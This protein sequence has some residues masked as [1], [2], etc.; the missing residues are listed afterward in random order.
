MSLDCFHLKLLLLIPAQLSAQQPALVLP[1]PMS[2]SSTVVMSS[3]LDDFALVFAELGLWPV[4]VE[5]HPGSS[6][7][8]DLLQRVVLPLVLEAG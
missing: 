2:T 3:M 8:V 1:E 4:V 7:R 5:L 6:E